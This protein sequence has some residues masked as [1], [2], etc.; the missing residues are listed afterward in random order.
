MNRIAGCLD[1]W[2]FIWGNPCASDVP[3]PMAKKGFIEQ[4]DGDFR[5][6]QVEN[7]EYKCIE[8]GQGG[9]CSRWTAYESSCN[10]EDFGIC[11]CKRPAETGRYCEKW[12]C[13]SK[14][15]EQHVCWRENCCNNDCDKPCVECGVHGSSPFPMNEGIYRSLMHADGTSYILDLDRNS[16]E[17]DHKELVE[18][19][20]AHWL[21]F[22]YSTHCIVPRDI[23]SVHETACKIWREIETEIQDCECVKHHSSGYFCQEWRCEE[24]DVGMFSILFAKSASYRGFLQG[25]EEENYTCQDSISND[26]GVSRCTKWKGL[27]RSFEEVE[28]TQCV[29]TCQSTGDMLCDSWAC[30]EYELPRVLDEDQWWKRLL[31]CAL[32]FLWI[33]PPVAVFTV[34]PWE[35][36][37]WGRLIAGVL[38][39]SGLVIG[40]L[41][42]FVRHQQAENRWIWPA[43][44][45]L[46]IILTI[47]LPFLAGLGLAEVFM[48]K[49]DR[50]SLVPGV[51]T[52]LTFVVCAGLWTT[53]LVGALILVT[54]TAILLSVPICV[55]MRS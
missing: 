50:K 46:G 23:K 53:G 35:E 45:L 33:L 48:R 14:E 2:S 22:T 25:I 11:T 7:E 32:H 8:R 19:R 28:M 24:K 17:T 15:A 6:G 27:I 34:L 49:S 4:T 5:R 37:P 38:G 47:F 31:F 3:V 29:A 51:T 26:A 16:N 55:L 10:E 42:A 54:L 39:L 43:M 20:K 12:R 9:H 36:L 52:V 40:W 18:L 41:I 13:I 44:P 21:D 30:N 1:E